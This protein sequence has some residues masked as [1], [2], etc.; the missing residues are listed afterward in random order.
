MKTVSFNL[1]RHC[2]VPGLVLLVLGIIGTS[3]YPLFAGETQTLIESS[4]FTNLLIDELPLLM[5]I[6][7]LARQLSG[8]K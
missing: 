6:M 5:L 2:L 8:K 1:N 3:I 4:S 7:T